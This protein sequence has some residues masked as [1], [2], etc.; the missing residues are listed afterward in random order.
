MKLSLYDGYFDP[1]EQ[2]MKDTDRPCGPVIENIVNIQYNFAGHTITFANEHDL[3]VAQ[4][5]TG[6][7]R[8]HQ[9]LYLN[10]NWF[11]GQTVTNEQDQTVYY[12]YF[13]ITD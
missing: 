10:L 11:E 4:Q 1:Y 13:D 9:C 8:F 2:S 5:K 12:E 7:T 6:W 3:L